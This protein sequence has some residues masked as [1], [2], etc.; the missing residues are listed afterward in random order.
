MS[1]KKEFPLGASLTLESLTNNIY[2]ILHQLRER[3]PITW[4]PTLQAWLVTSRDW[5]VEMMRDAKTYTV[6]HP[7]FST[8]QV[9]GSSMLS[10]D[11]DAHQRH[12]LPFER[13]F[14]KRQVRQRFRQPVNHHIQTLLDGFSH[15]G[16][17]ELRRQFA[18]PVSVLTMMTA[19][20]LEEESVT[21]VLTWY[22]AI[23]DAVTRVSAGE[24]VSSE[25]KEAFAALKT[26]LLHAIQHNDNSLLAAASGTTDQLSDD[27]IVSN[28]AVLL[29][30]GIE[31]TEGMI[32]NALYHLLTHP[33]M[34]AELKKD[35]ALISS[36]VE[37]SLRLEPAASV[38]DRYTT[39]AVTLNEIHIPAGELVRLSLVAANRDP[40]TFPNPDQFDPH[41]P[42]LRDHVTFAQGPHVCLGLHLARLEVET[43]VAQLI[44]HLPNLRLA[45]NKP[46]IPPTGLIFRKP[47][48]LFVQW[49]VG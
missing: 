36:V 9:V 34:V 13:P 16:H 43:A 3:E 32:T 26:S 17:A 49:D 7:G 33:H 44:H 47:D 38:L 27:E 5:V 23:V 12:R 4:V 37:E 18:G 6:D 22:D 46:I 40:A 10:L 28:A 41:R 24:P 48:T 8:A 21:A 25:G 45:A 31:T 39:T 20:G 29:F 2:P 15:K 1:R 30:G 35:D 11:G 19:L 42:N 14:R